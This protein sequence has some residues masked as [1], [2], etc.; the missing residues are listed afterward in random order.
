VIVNNLHVK[1]ALPWAD[2]ELLYRH[3]STQIG[4]KILIEVALESFRKRLLR[5]KKIKQEVMISDV[6]R[7]MRDGMIIGDALKKWIPDDE[8]MVLSAGQESGQLP[9]SLNL[10]IESK[11]RIGRVMSAFK[12]ALIN[13]VIYLF[14]TFGMLY[15]I[16]AFVVPGLEGSLPESKA[17]GS[18]LALYVVGNFANSWFALIPVGIVLVLFLLV[19]YSLPVWTGDARIAA[20]KFFPYSFYRDMHGYLWLI[21]FAQLLGAGVSNTTI[22]TRQKQQGSPWFKERISTILSRM[23]NGMSL[24]AALLKKGRS[25]YGFGFPNPDIVDDIESMADFSDFPDKITILAMQWADDLERKTLAGAKS[26]GLAME[27]AMYLIMGALMV[28]INS[29]SSQLSAV[30]G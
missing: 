17:K 21:G 22:L 12:A 10:I 11:R 2:R 8:Y 28:A 30:H 26:F 29:L 1:K 16:G 20:E 15:A 27:M 19:A 23:N 24:S 18:V 5:R 9:A 6:S 7:K 25:G 13:P 4:N 14:L 3:L